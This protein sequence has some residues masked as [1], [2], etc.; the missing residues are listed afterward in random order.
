MMRKFSWM[1]LVLLAFWAGCQE[2][3][4]VDPPKVQEPSTVEQKVEPVAAQLSEEEVV[5]GSAEELKTVSA[6]KIVWKKDGAKMVLIPE[7][8]SGTGKKD[9]VYN[10]FG[11]V[12]GGG[13]VVGATDVFF[14]DA[15]EVT[16][17]QFKTFLKSSGY[18]PDLAIDWVRVHKYSPTDKHPMNSVTWHDTTAYAKWA[19]KRLPTETEWEYAAR[20]GLVGKQYPWGDGRDGYGLY[21]LARDYANY[22]GTGGGEF[23]QDD[24][25]WEYASPVGSFKPNG[26]GLYDMA[27][28]VSE[29][30]QDWYSSD[31][32]YQVL[33]GGSWL[34]D[35]YD[36]RVANRNHGYDPIFGYNGNGFRCVSGLP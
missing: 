11:D 13:E 25:R 8:K 18:K 9:F 31:R 26:Y 33:R 16:V 1:L 30:C 4:T 27:G 12:V 23:G 20:G 21:D 28:N 17:G 32:E 2:P 7:N 19:G 14:M 22:I 29:W 36:L 3:S 15:Y 6:K 34:N 35:P 5:I 24:D 10:E